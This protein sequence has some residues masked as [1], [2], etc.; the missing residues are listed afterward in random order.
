MSDK[1]DPKTNTTDENTHPKKPTL[2]QKIGGGAL[3]IFLILW[4][5]GGI[6]ALITSIVCFGM[7]GSIMEKVIGLVLAFFLGPLYFIFY[8]VNKNYCKRMGSNVV[9]SMNRAIYG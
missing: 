9:N 3:F 5:L 7:S 6:A 1:I 4:M 2:G 8:G